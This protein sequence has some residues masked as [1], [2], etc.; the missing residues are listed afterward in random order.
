MKKEPAGGGAGVDRIGEAL[1]IYTPLLQFLYRLHQLA[2]TT[3][4]PIQ[5]PDH[6][7]IWFADVESV[8]DTETVS[9]D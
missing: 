2:Y 3:P 4:Q 7:G 1:K 8:P 5:L 9:S 6:K